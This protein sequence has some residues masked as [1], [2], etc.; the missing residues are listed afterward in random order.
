MI[1]WMFIALLA[2][3][4]W[5]FICDGIL[6]PSLRLRIRYRLFAVRDN[7]RALQGQESQVS[8]EVFHV[9][10][11]NINTAIELVPALSVSLISTAERVFR[12]DP[13]LREWV[14]ARV[15]IVDSCSIE[16]VQ[17]VR[18]RMIALVRDALIVNTAGWLIWVI[19]IAG[20]LHLVRS[21]P[22][23]VVLPIQKIQ[24]VAP[25]SFQSPARAIAS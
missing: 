11:E 23:L 16:E 7:L 14:E 25:T 20:I 9:L 22:K 18:T 15:R 24:D 3:A 8:A 4:L 19:P 17:D 10:H 2:L 1:T 5:H 13:D 12:D 21:I 6:A